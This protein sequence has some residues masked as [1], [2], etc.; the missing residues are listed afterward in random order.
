MNITYIDR[1][2]F[3]QT[4]ISKMTPANV[5]LD[6]GTG[7]MPRDYVPANFYICCEP[8][9]QYVGVLKENIKSLSPNT[10]Y[11]VMNCDWENALKVLT[12]KSVD[13][14]FIIDVV[15][16]LEK[17]EGERLLKDTLRVAR[18]QVVVFTPLGFLEQYL[19]PD[20]KDA[21]GLDGAAVQE[22]KSGWMPSDFDA[23]W[24]ILVCKDYHVNDN[25]G[26]P[27]ETPA[28]A[29]WAIKNIDSGATDLKILVNKN[30]YDSIV[31]SV[32]LYRTQL[33]RINSTSLVRVA[34]FVVNIVRHIKLRL[35][36]KI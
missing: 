30:S 9:S 18:K 4:A 16:H 14:V 21:W 20:G 27:Y 25:L 31:K 11:L 10:Q 13:T 12:D 17:D 24:E 34:K 33:E 32:E 19:H 36:F 2:D 6:I 26:N 7:I 22:H 1:S 23:S 35:G 29:F 28:G 3:T 15:E 8:F 5:L